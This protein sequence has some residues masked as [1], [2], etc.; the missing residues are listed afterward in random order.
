MCTLSHCAHECGKH[1]EKTYNLATALEI[2][3]EYMKL[4]AAHISEK[5]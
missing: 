3:T 1:V 4:K 5:R 2:A